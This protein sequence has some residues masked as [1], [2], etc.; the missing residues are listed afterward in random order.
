MVVN[1]VRALMWQ[2]GGSGTVV[3]GGQQGAE[4]YVQS[5]NAKRYGGFDDWRLPTLEEAMSLMMPPDGGQPLQTSGGSAKVH[6]ASA[7]E[8]AGAFFIWTSD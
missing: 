5:L 6:L 3:Q 1:P 7:F 2:R 4:Q 8:T